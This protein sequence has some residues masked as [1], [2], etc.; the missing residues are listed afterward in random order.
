MKFEVEKMPVFS[1]ISPASCNVTL[2][3]GILLSSCG[4]LDVSPVFPEGS[5]STLTGGNV[6]IAL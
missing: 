6:S 1:S 2:V 4:N 3:S 5:V